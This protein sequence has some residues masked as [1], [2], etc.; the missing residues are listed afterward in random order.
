MV[1]VSI[2]TVI[3]AIDVKIP[4]DAGN[5]PNGLIATKLTT[6]LLTSGTDRIRKAVKTLVTWG[7]SAWANILRLTKHMI[8]FLVKPIDSSETQR[9]TSNSMECSNLGG[10]NPQNPKEREYFLQWLVGFVDGDGSF[11]FTKSNGK[12]SLIFKVSQST[13]NLRVLHYIKSQL[14]VGSIVIE[15]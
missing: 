5:S 12:W 8:C 14:G 11:T 3:V 6:R 9:G 4:L 13:Y 7:Q 1:S 10:N 2:F 15:L